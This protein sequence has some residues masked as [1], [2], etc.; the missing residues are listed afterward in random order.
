[1]TRDRHIHR[2]GERGA[3]LLAVLVIVA[4]MSVTAV[5]LVD[6]IRFGIRR[7]TAAEANAQAFWYAL[8]AEEY[9]RAMIE[10]ED[11]KRLNSAIGRGQRFDIAAGA[12]GGRLLDGSNCFNVN[13][14]VTR[15]DGGHYR[16]R[17]E[18][19]D[20]YARLLSLI[21]IREQRHR[22]LG[23]TLADWIDSDSQPMN[24]GAEDYH[25]ARLSPP[26]RTGGTLMA[27][28]SELRAVRGYELAT[29]QAI[30]PYVCA[31]PTTA[32][33]TIN[34][35]T[36]TE[37]QAPLLSMAVGEALSLE[38]ARRVLSV[39]P[40]GGFATIEAFWATEEM[41]D[42][43]RTEEIDAQISLETTYVTLQAEVFY[44]DAYFALTSLFRRRADGKPVLVSRQFGGVT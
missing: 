40:E 28:T 13:S 22:A 32:R 10:R 37:E 18:A 31:L 5:A 14:L 2:N 17:P 26:Y 8:G 19:L 23:N 21:D 34:I 16:A 4:V 9:A 43:P 1:M 39:R 6:D 44:G 42:I 3:I 41:R 38:D 29:Y 15:T 20:Q 35:N 30:A 33:T 25:Y 36:L 24:R 27:D 7:S 11:G 12:M